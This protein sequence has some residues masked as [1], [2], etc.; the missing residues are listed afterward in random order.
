ML[1]KIPSNKEINRRVLFNE[2]NKKADYRGTGQIERQMMTNAICRLIDCGLI[3]GKVKPYKLTDKQKIFL[4]YI[5]DSAKLFSVH[6]SNR[7][8]ILDRYPRGLNTYTLYGT[9]T[10]RSLI[11]KR[12]VEYMGNGN[13]E[14]T[15][16]G[17]LYV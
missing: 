10:L 12:L 7:G 16:Q 9:S 8:F 15:K 4:K 1:R 6:K 2:A 5:E 3:K 14:L 13:I 17:E 11:K